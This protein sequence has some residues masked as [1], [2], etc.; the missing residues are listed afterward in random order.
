MPLV[1]STLFNNRSFSVII[2]RYRTT[3]KSC[4]RMATDR[5]DCLG[6]HDTS[7]FPLKKV[8]SEGSWWSAPCWP[9][10]RAAPHPQ[11]CLHLEVSGS[12]KGGGEDN[13]GSCAIKVD[14]DSLRKF[15]VLP[16]EKNSHLER[17]QEGPGGHSRGWLPFRGHGDCQQTHSTTRP[18]F[19]PF[20]FSLTPQPSN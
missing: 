8:L 11:P 16:P 14:L 1:Y 5:P 20:P 7:R 3:Y 6:Q 18:P 10:E 15:S 12:G 17:S 13:S 9:E 2:S 19:Q 4:L